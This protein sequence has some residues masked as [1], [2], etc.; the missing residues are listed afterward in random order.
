MFGRQVRYARRAHPTKPRYWLEGKYWGRLNL[1]RND[2]WTFGDKQT[3][4]YLQKFAWFAIE[5]HVLVKGPASPDDPSLRIYWQKRREK[6]KS[7]LSLSWQN[8]AKNQNYTCPVCGQSLFNDE[9]LHKHHIQPRRENGP[10]T[11]KNYPLLHLHWHQQLTAQPHSEN[12][13]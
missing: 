10:D 5:R 12:T 7:N 8:I 4:R 9:E 2:T 6:H 13:S 1:D 11:Y 3:G